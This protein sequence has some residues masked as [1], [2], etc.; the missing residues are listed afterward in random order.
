MEL[1]E[2]WTHRSWFL[3]NLFNFF[4]WFGCGLFEFEWWE[5]YI[6]SILTTWEAQSFVSALQ[7]GFLK[8]WSQL[9]TSESST[10][11]ALNL[12]KPCS[13]FNLHKNISRV[14]RKCIRGFRRFVAYILNSSI[15]KWEH[16][17]MQKQSASKRWGP[18]E[19]GV[20]RTKYYSKN[21][22]QRSKWGAPRLRL[23]IC[24]W[25]YK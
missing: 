3:Y 1:G 4:I 8:R 16:H 14:T 7:F 23:Y 15:S 5:G 12:K 20:C 11:Q 13:P 17:N 22:P 18:F 25:D 21:N 24:K 19:A 6:W 10:K 2:L 9:K